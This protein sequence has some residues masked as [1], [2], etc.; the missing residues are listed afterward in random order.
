MNSIAAWFFGLFF[1]IFVGNT[2]TH[3]VVRCLREKINRLEDSEGQ[4]YA[5]FTFLLG[6]FESILYTLSYVLGMHF[7]IGVWL[8]VKM[9]GRWSSRESL[10]IKK[11]DVPR[12]AIN[13][14]LIGNLIILLFGI[15]GG[16]ITKSILDH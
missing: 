4:P 16:S 13:I 3:F 12:G 7:L 1:S 9:A 15:I 11:S 8:A 14:F 5:R 2:V 10:D 6:I